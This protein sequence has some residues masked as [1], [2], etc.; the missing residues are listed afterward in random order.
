PEQRIADVL[1]LAIHFPKLSIELSPLNSKHSVIVAVEQAQGRTQVHTASKAAEV[2]GIFSGMPINAAY[3]LC[4]TIEVVRY[5]PDRQRQ[6]LEEMA[7][8]AGQFTSKVSIDETSSL[9][10][11]VL[12]SVRLFGGLETLLQVIHERLSLQWSYQVNFA[13]T[14]TPA[15]SVLLA[16]IAEVPTDSTTIGTHHV[17]IV[18]NIEALRSRLGMVRLSRL[19]LNKKTHKQL[20]RLG[21]QTLRDLL[22]LP[23][24]D[25]ARRYGKEIN[26]YLN[27]LLGVL[28]QPQNFQRRTEM[29]RS[30]WPLAFET[31]N[32][33]IISQIVANL[34]Q[35]LQQFLCQRD[36]SLRAYD[37][38]FEH[39]KKTPTRLAIRFRQ[40]NRDADRF[41]LL[42]EERF[43]QFRIDTAVIGVRLF[44]EHLEEFTAVNEDLC[45]S[46]GPSF[47]KDSHFLENP[48]SSSDA[49]INKLLELLQIRMGVTAIS[50]L[51]VC[52]DH[53]PEDA[54][55]YEHQNKQHNSLHRSSH[56][57]SPVAGYDKNM[58]KF[59]TNVTPYDRPL[60][61]LLTP[62]PLQRSNGNL[63]YKTVLTLSSGPERIESGW[64]S[65]DNIRRDYYVA[66]SKDA[67]KLWIYQ[68]LSKPYRWYVHGFFA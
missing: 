54:Y 9:L 26:F 63:Y 36:A 56:I 42:F 8:W 45:F 3:S 65:D 24:A 39:L 4:P 19:P 34:L 38:Y 51:H 61:L 66:T 49:G 62:Q 11:E 52:A 13:V 28:P 20:H 40:A 33:Q 37:V 30:A 1:W 60:W 57:R 16:S 53:R 64:W 27:R 7:L 48:D 14:P 23:K 44:A 43:Q 35:Q 21:L 18:D 47:S 6:R 46:K 67:Q 59:T 22:R 17:V 58:G 5:E 10:L 32:G 25:V 55:R 29:F 31:K 41:L 2:R 68:E 50:T 12:G 15:A